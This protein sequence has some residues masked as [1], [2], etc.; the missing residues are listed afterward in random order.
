MDK[1]NLFTV[2]CNLFIQC[3]S[4]FLKYIN[5]GYFYTANVYSKSSIQT[6]HSGRGK[7]AHPS[8]KL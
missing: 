6:K 2:K 8:H 4:L 1:S 7:L 5:L 3:I